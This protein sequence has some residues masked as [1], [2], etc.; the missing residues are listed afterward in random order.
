M[1]K[2]GNEQQ[3]KS[4]ELNASQRLVIVA[5]TITA[6]TRQSTRWL[7]DRGLDV[8]CVEVQRFEFPSGEIGFGAVTVVD[9]DETRAETDSGNKPGIE[10]LR[11]T[12]SPVHFQK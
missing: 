9:Y 10:S 1:S 3:L 4:W 8:Q 7:R 5:E 2:Y 12:C 6:Q 11:T